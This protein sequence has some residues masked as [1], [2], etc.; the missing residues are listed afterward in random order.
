AAIAVDNSLANQQKLNW[1]LNDLREKKSAEATAKQVKDS[2]DLD[3]SKADVNVGQMQFMVNLKKK[4]WDEIDQNLKNA[5]KNLV[6]RQTQYDAALAASKVALN[7][8]SDAEGE[9]AAARAAINTSDSTL[10]RQIYQYYAI[11][12]GRFPEPAGINYWLNDLRRG[13]SPAVFAYNLYKGSDSYTRG[14]SPRDLFARS[15]HYLLGRN[16]GDTYNGMDEW[17]AALSAAADT[18]NSLGQVFVDFLNRTLNATS[19]NDKAGKDFLNSRTDEVMYASVQ[20]ALDK[21]K[22]ASDHFDEVKGYEK[23]ANQNLLDAQATLKRAP[24][25]T[26]AKDDYDQAVRN[27]DEAVKASNNAYTAANTAADDYRKATSAAQSAQ[28][29]VSA[30]AS[31]GT[32]PSGAA[33]SDIN[34]KLSTYN[35]AQGIAT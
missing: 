32:P 23:S 22:T 16:D 17:G 5:Q 24:D 21:L 26:Q 33:T 2:R 25:S 7:A 8:K 4:D 1:A 15:Y 30:L 14:L 11:I 28:D 35:I 12:L 34:A 10:I 13:D 18:P 27:L 19:G 31:A 6:D 3:H 20:P 29:L 9:V